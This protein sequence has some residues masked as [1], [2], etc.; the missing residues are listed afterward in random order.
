M[1]GTENVEDFANRLR[2]N[3]RRLSKWLQREQIRAWRLYDADI[4]EYAVAVDC[5]LSGDAPWQADDNQHCHVVVQEYQP[6]SR[7]DSQRAEARLQAI[8]A[9]LPDVLGCPSE[10]VRLKV[11]QRQR[12]QQQY[13]RSG[14]AGEMIEVDEYGAR[15]LVNLDDYLDT[16]LFLDHRKVRH[17]IFEQASGKRFLNLF[18]YTATASVHAARG[19]ASSTL[20]LDLSSRYCQ[21]AQQ[22]LAN[23]GC[24]TAAHTVQRVDVLGWLENPPAAAQFDLIL[25][26]PPTFSNSSSMDSNWDVQRDH[27]AVIHQCM[28]LLAVDGCLI[29]SNNFRQFRLDPALAGSFNIDDRSRWSLHPDFERNQ[30]IHRCWFI[31]HPADTGTAGNDG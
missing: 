3:Q 22:N 25:L 23:N 4:P 17:Y 13:Q 19:G 27:A 16:G 10:Q 18:A 2:K 6:P 12:G 9:V 8:M 15:L 11:R 7:V 21:W 26:D 20:S 1:A 14:H 30:R 31:R 5:Y 29:F 24:N 28:A